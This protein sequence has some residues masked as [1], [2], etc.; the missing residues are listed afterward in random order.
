MRN[1]NNRQRFNAC[2]HYQPVDRAPLVDFGFWD[3]TVVLWHRQG[4]PAWV[5]NHKPESWVSFFDM[6]FTLRKEHA[7]VKV[8]WGLSPEF[9]KQ[10]VEDRGEEEVFQQADGVRVL[11]Q[12][13]MRSIPKPQR[14]L[15]TNRESW[16]KYYLPRLDPTRSQ[17][18]PHDWDAQ[19]KVW[20]D[21]QRHHPVF[22]SGG[23]LYGVL[24]NWMGMENLSLV[25]YDDPAWFEEM[26]TTLADN[27]IAILTRFLETGGRFDGCHMWED[28]CYNAGPLLSPRHFKKFL[29]P[30]YKRITSLLRRYGVDVVYLDCDGNIEALMPLWL[31]AG[32]NC[33]FPL[34]IGTW[35]ADPIRY[36][37]QYGRDLLIM[38]GF[39]KH[40]L[41]GSKAEIEKEVYR[42]LPL[43]EEGGFIGFCDHLVPPDVPFE[44]YCFYVNTIRQ[45]WG[46]GLK[47]LNFSG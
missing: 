38:G 3:E 16:K 12:K 10:V 45:V 25:V 21:D 40:L 32:V 1:M 13:F 31:E 36:R 29:L 44:N 11:R 34:E 19:V 7:R 26:V 22:L 9:R 41:A 35:G 23:S 2:M 42:L 27:Y 47:P 46:G 17:R 6:D 4:L 37:R 5:K 8:K 39:D 24:R 14:Y 28:M 43:V 30:Q 33:M 15:L 20:R 18:Y